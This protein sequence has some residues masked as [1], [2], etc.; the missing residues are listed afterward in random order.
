MASLTPGVLTKLLKNM[1][2]D[3]KISGE[4]R[5]TLLQVISIVP[6]MTGSELWPDHGFFI[7][8]SD[9]SHST[10]V[11]LSKEGDELILSNQ[12][13]LGQFIYVDR[14]QAGTPV[15]VLVGVRPVPG[16]SPCI[17]NPK[18]LMQM[19]VASELRGTNSHGVATP[20]LSGLAESKEVVPRQR[21]VIKEEKPGVASRYMQGV[22]SSKVKD[23]DT[24][25]NS[26]GRNI[27]GGDHVAE[28]QRKARSSDRK[29]RVGKLELQGSPTTTHS[30]QST[31]EKSKPPI[32][33]NSTKVAP[34]PKSAASTPAT[35]IKQSAAFELPCLIDRYKKRVQV[36]IISWESLPPNMVGPGKGILRRRNVAY[37][38]AA[39]A[40][41]E[42]AAAAALVKS[43][44]QDMTTAP[45]FLSFIY[46]HFFST[47]IS[48]LNI[49][50]DLRASAT[51]KNPHASLTKFFTLHQLINHPSITNLKEKPPQAPITLQPSGTDWTDKHSKRTFMASDKSLDQTESDGIEKLQWVK[52]DT[53]RE[54]QELRAMLL[55][56]SQSWFLEFLEG[57]L[58]SGFHAES[59]AKKGNNV[60]CAGGQPKEACGQIAVTLSQLKLA[61]DWLDQLQESSGGDCEGDGLLKTVDKLKQKI[62]ACLLGQVDSA[63]SALENRTNHC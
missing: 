62:Y 44:R 39:E 61:N 4:Y 26:R 43:L 42:A 33:D 16:R 5:S 31:R 32:G 52:G 34:A 8:V 24:G 2:S 48:F 51:T 50:A 49:Y 25:T 6:A 63:A 7:K 56:E 35:I 40:Q 47:P 22:S 21:V 3:V 23:G 15:P 37:M 60:G 11:S 13:R 30:N 41:K 57:A 59:H 36:S 10:Y 17:G 29:T 28:S 55:K 54:I 53:T 12:L 9:S 46:N 1:N 18:D 45:G 14:V 27:I 38:V 19:L 20:R 58:S